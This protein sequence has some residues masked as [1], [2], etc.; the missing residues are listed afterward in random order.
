MAEATVAL[1]YFN[2][3]RSNMPARA[4]GCPA[5]THFHGQFH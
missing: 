1:A 4:R 5:C 2:P 3:Y